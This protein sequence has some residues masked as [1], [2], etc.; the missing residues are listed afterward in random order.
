MYVFGPFYVKETENGVTSS[1]CEVWVGQA[2]P[3]YVCYVKM[4]KC[5]RIVDQDD[6]NWTQLGNLCCLGTV[7]SVRSGDKLFL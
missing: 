1:N 7:M 6:K 4:S 3:I 2:N 5:I